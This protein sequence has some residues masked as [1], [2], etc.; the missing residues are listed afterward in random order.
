MA[1]DVPTS[2]R[3]VLLSIFITFG[4]LFGYNLGVISGCLI[5]P[6]FIRRF[7][8]EGTNGQYYLSSS[9][10]SIIVSLLSAGG[11]IAQAF[12]SDRFGRRGSILFWSA[13]FTVGVAIQTGTTY[14]IVQLVI[15][16][17]VAGLGVGALSAIVPLYSG[18]TA[19]KAIRGTILVIYQVQI[20]SGIFLSYLF[21]LG[22]HTINNSASWRIPIGLQM[23]WGI[24]LLSGILLLQ[25]PES[26]RHLLGTGR[27]DE[28]RK[29]IAELNGVPEDDPLVAEIVEE[30]DFAIRAENEGGKATWLECFSTRNALWR[31]TISGMILQFIQQL[32]GQ[33]FYYYYGDTFFQSAGAGRFSSCNNR[34]SP[35]IIQTI[36]GAVSVVGTLPA[37]HF[38]ETWGR[39][40]S[41]LLGAS[42]QAVCALIVAVVGHTILAPTG[43]PTSALT[44]RNRAGGNVVITFAIFQVFIFGTTWGATP[45]IYLAESF[46]LR[47]RPK[48]IALGIAINWFWNFMLS[49]FSPRIVDRIGP[50]IM[51]V[52]FGVLVFGYIYV[53][54]TIPETQGL[55]LEE[56]DE[57]YCSGVAPWQSVGWR[58]SEKHHRHEEKPASNSAEEA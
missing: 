25:I 39:R 5:M 46:P 31:R 12:T 48:A 4:F 14:S 22:S 26:P 34:L 18:E 54:F 9:R 36:L 41:M 30:L 44:A 49:F 10:Q 37:L 43:T 19:P 6:D 23:V 28:A 27:D 8:Q 16:R 58:P 24:I 11:A 32:N 40:K 52:F 21:E 3:A 51:L 7:G 13:I 17:Y 29:V 55:T 2:S 33:N 35:Y 45:W 50:M 15:G 1:R 53:Y 47:V 42:T 38:I 56:V 20:I 57:L